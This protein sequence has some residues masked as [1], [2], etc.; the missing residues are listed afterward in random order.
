MMN[1]PIARSPL[2]AATLALTLIASASAAQTT[3]TPTTPQTPQTESPKAKAE[4]HGNPDREAQR[5]EMRE[6]MQ[7]ADT[8]ND[9]QFSR[10]EWLAAGRRDRGF[11]MMDSDKNG[12]L[13]RDELRTGMEQMRAMRGQ[14]GR[15]P[16]P[17]NQPD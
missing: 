16:G 1:T 2:R 7:A 15:G 11:D 4:R 13:T 10:E 17:G 12:Q 14:G 6:R 8:N 3:P 5:A 9:G